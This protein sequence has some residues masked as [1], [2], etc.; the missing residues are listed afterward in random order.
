MVMQTRIC[1]L[2]QVVLTEHAEIRAQQR[3]I[4]RDGLFLAALYGESVRGREGSERRTITKKAAKNMERDG[5]DT[6]LVE[7][8]KGTV[9]I[10]KEE[11][12]ERVIVTVGYP[13][14]DGR[15]GGGFR[16]VNPRR[17]RWA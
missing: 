4:K 6:R 7:S 1:R 13:E 2:D 12:G 17:H 14:K 11:P 10:T 15:R 5:Y 3:G 9:V 16:K 8:I